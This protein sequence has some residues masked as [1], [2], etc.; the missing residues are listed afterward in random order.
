MPDRVLIDT[1][2]WVRHL[3]NGCDTLDWLLREE[4]VSCHPF[5]V[6]ELACGNLASRSEIL[7]L[8][9]ALPQALP[10]IHTEVLEFI[11]RHG[12]MGKGLGYV[13]I[14]LLGS[15]LVSGVSLWTE[16][17]S[18]GQAAISLGVAAGVE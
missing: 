17:R 13:D 8:L 4:R 2:V 16:D 18:L 11:E 1:S 12:L 9:Q 7:T 6:G 15:S 14:H 3:R 10:L 5:V